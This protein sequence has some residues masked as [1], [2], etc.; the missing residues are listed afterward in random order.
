MWE[1]IIVTKNYEQIVDKL[2]IYDTSPR[3]CKSRDMTTIRTDLVKIEIYNMHSPE[4]LRGHK[5]DLIYI[6]DEW[7]D[8]KIIRCEVL[9]P[10]APY[11]TVRP[12]RDLKRKLGLD[13]Y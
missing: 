12:I 2:I 13:I 11:G 9:M 10:M 4:N 8:D 1:I 6:D 5:A 3:V 7:Y